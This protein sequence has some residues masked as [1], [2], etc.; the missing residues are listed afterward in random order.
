MGAKKGVAAITDSWR[1]D[2]ASSD[3][4]VNTE[5]SV[6]ARYRRIV[7]RPLVSVHAVSSSTKELG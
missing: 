5:G 1:A 6:V 2:C 4:I 3:M 7:E